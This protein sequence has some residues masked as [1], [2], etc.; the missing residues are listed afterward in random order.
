MDKS[1]KNDVLEM[2][3]Q[4]MMGEH[5]KKLKPAAVSIEVV[6]PVKKSGD[7]KDVLDR[8]GERMPMTR[9]QGDI[10]GDGDHD[11][12][13][14]ALEEEAKMYEDVEEGRVP[15]MEDEDEYEEE[16]E[17]EDEEDKPKAKS[18]RDFFNR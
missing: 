11:L 1:I 18:F 17:D 4:F 12:H 5:G 3:K 16:C 6:E 14:H 10:D 8:A 15:E 9:A 2:L 7:L 13:D